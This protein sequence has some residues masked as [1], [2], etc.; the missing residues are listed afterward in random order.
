MTV[1]FGDNLDLLKSY[2]NPVDIITQ[3]NSTYK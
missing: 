2:P 3:C 1:D